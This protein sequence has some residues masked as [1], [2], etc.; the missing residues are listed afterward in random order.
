MFWYFSRIAAR[1]ARGDCASRRFA[2]RMSLASIRALAAAERL[3]AEGRENDLLPW[4]ALGSATWTLSARAV[5]DW[6]PTPDAPD[7]DVFGKNGVAAE[8]AIGRV[9]CP[10]LAWYGA[11]E[12]AGTAADLDYIRAAAREA[13]RVDTRLFEAAD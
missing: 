2:S 4:G 10:V 13:P 6:H 12:D 7:R 1:S 8:P 9:R 5:V 3:V 11:D